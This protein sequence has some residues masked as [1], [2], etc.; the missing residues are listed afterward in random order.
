MTDQQVV[1]LVF[2]S[3]QLVKLLR[4]SEKWLVQLDDS[5]YFVKHVKQL[6]VGD[7]N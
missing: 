6:T 3:V 1:Q 7:V 4:K 5:R 2:S